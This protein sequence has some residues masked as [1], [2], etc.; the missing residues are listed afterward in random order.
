MIITP[1]RGIECSL[2]PKEVET[3]ENCITLLKNIRDTMNE[4]DYSY[5]HVSDESEITNGKMTD[6]I[7]KLT[8]LTHIDEMY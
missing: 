8:D 4:Y 6:L 5:L 1:P 7:I 3:I 2:E